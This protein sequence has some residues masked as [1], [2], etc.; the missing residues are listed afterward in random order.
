MVPLSVSIQYRN[1][2]LTRLETH[3]HLP[4]QGLSIAYGLSQYHIKSYHL[5]SM[6]SLIPT[7]FP[8][9]TSKPSLSPPLYILD[10]IS[11]SVTMQKS[12][13]GSRVLVLIIHNFCRYCKSL[14]CP[15]HVF[16][17]WLYSSLDLPMM[18]IF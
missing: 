1:F 4:I 14:I 5:K 10:I 8:V 15:S 11:Y 13:S 12:H 18:Y 3:N 6:Y 16:C 2:D 9:N 7:E 17:C